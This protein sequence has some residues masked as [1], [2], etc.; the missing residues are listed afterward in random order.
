MSASRGA[1]A[2][3][4]CVIARPDPFSIACVGGGS[5]AIV[6]LVVRASDVTSCF[7]IPV[8][9]LSA[10]AMLMRP[11]GGVIVRGCSNCRERRGRHARRLSFGARIASPAKI[12]G[13]S[14]IPTN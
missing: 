4:S 9:V 8:T 3:V 6:A 10:G 11:S 1:R 13:L 12:C 14:P 7:G 2:V 5:V